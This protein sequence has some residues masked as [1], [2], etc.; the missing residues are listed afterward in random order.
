MEKK[1]ASLKENEKKN[2][3][4]FKCKGYCPSCDSDVTFSSKNQDFRSSFWCENCESRPRE[5]ALMKVIEEHYPNWRELKIHES[6]PANR[7]TSIKLSRQC[8]NYIRSQY[9]TSFPLG[10][11]HRDG[12]Y[13]ENLENQTFDDESFDLV[14]T[15]D[16]MEHIFDID[17]AFKEIART[18]GPGGAHI[19]TTPLVNFTNPTE[20]WARKK[21]NGDIEFLHKPEYHGNPMN[22]KGALVTYHFGYDICDRIFNACK[23]HTAIIRIDDLRYGIRARLNEVLVSYKP[24]K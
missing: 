4:F 19:F 21:R 13:C 20:E 3:I 18:L 10:C 17:S 12:Y 9:D 1:E 8:K 6:S 11:I 23:L 5:R 15:Q 7:A 24:K 14:I 22:P 16:V 2:E